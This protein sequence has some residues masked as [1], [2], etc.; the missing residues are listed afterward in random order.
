MKYFVIGNGESRKP[1]DISKLKGF[2]I[3]CNAIY[4]YETVD[5]VCAVDRFWINKISKECNIPLLSRYHNHMFQTHLELYSNGKWKDT[6]CKFRYY[7]SGGTAFDYIGHLCKEEDTV[8][9]LGFDL[10]YKGETV[11]HIYK[12]TR[13][14]PPATIK[15]QTSSK[16]LHEVEEV[17]RRYPRKHFVYVNDDDVDLPNKLSIR[18]FLLLK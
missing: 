9:L 3:G 2:K 15:A 13:F 6:D 11:D 7:S 4:L 17:Y 10:G 16:F 8:Y 5:M 18:E 14:H 12:G 1:I